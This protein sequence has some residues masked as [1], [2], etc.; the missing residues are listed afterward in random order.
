[1]PAQLY[2]NAKDGVIIVV[3]KV[4]ISQRFREVYTVHQANKPALNT[5]DVKIAG[6]HKCT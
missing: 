1:M 6:H 5:L 3:I 2:L 4:W